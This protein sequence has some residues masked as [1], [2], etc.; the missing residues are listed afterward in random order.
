MVVE[1]S[2]WK[3]WVK[4]S[5]SSPIF[6][7]KK[8][9]KPPP[10]Y[11]MLFSTSLIYTDSIRN[12]QETRQTPCWSTW[13][14]RRSPGQQKCTVG[15]TQEILAKKEVEWEKK[16]LKWGR[17]WEC[18]KNNHID[19]C[20]SYIIFEGL[21]CDFLLS[22]S[23]FWADF[24]DPLKRINFHAREIDG[25][26]CGKMDPQRSKMDPPGDNPQDNHR[27]LLSEPPGP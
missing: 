8:K 22:F 9:W 17:N 12:P 26:R 1:P 27:H 15:G 2:S 5:S 23:R 16:W 11:C 3:I 18:M 25:Q 13:R 21:K 10:R 6:G 19:I 20:V 4:L 7:V 24:E 14:L